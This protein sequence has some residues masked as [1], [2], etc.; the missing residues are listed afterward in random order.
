MNELRLNDFFF[1]VVKNKDSVSILALTAERFLQSRRLLQ[2][3][4]TIR[5]EAT[6]SWRKGIIKI[7]VVE[8]RV[9]LDLAIRETRWSFAWESKSGTAVCTTDS[10]SASMRMHTPC[11]AQ[12]A[13]Y[14]CTQMRGGTGKV[15]VPRNRREAP[16]VVPFFLFSSTSR[17]SGST[18]TSRSRVHSPSASRRNHN[19]PTTRRSEYI[20]TSMICRVVTF[21]AHGIVRE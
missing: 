5:D 9:F 12:R 3:V 17:R 19:R 7:K 21:D 10:I 6:S 20:S 2:R 1:M 13:A 15:N 18:G 8:A 14:T 11:N 16:S 4:V